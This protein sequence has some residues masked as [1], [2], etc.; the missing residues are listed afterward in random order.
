MRKS[1]TQEAV[2]ETAVRPK[3]TPI[4]KRDILTLKGKE[5]GYVYRIVNDTGDRI[6][7][8][9]EQGYEMVQA[10]D[11]RVGD[12]RINAATPEG[13]FAQVSVGGGQKAF[14]MRQKQEWYDEDQDAKQAEVNKL[15]QSM[16]Q[17]ALAQNELRNGKLD[18]TRD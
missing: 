12:K 3:R 7:A 9:K 17:Q 10:S 18:L 14:V 6:E 1:T 15:E 2:Q 5:P 16:R 8:L 13:S 11:V 4:N